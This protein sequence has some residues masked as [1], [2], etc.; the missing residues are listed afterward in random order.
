MLTTVSVAIAAQPGDPLDAVAEP[1]D[2][3]GDSV[4]HGAPDAPAWPGGCARVAGYGFGTVTNGRRR[5]TALRAVAVPVA[6]ASASP[7][8]GVAPLPL[9]TVPIP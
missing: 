9:L 7:A 2:G 6:V 3:V 1:L 5:A 4:L 8:A